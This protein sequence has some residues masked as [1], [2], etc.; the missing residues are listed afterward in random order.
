MVLG[1]RGDQQFETPRGR[2]VFT[3]INTALQINNLAQKRLPTQ[4]M[5]DWPD[6]VY[7]NAQ[8]TTASRL[9]DKVGLFQYNGWALVEESHS[10][11]I[12]STQMLL[13]LQEALIL[14]QNLQDWRKGASNIFR[15]WTTPGYSPSPSNSPNPR[16]AVEYPKRILLFHTPAAAATWANVRAARVRLLQTMLEI[17]VILA[18]AGMHLP[19]ACSWNILHAQLLDTVDSIANTIPY[20]LGEVDETGGLLMGGNV[21]P[22][23][24]VFAIWPLHVCALVKDVDDSYFSWIME[25]L[26]RIGNITGY[27]AAIALEKHHLIRRSSIVSLDTLEN[28]SFD[29]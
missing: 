9:M 29:V 10:S 11:N 17:N 15:P 19:P 25:Q 1:L 4:S 24:A 13:L 18:T 14:D 6:D 7:P 2:S 27:K 28:F 26:Y 21:Q 16:A 22:A 12:P 3:S 5:T 20:L 23:R 8:A